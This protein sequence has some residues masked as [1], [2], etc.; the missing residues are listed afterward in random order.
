M[1]GRGVATRRSYDEAGRLVREWAEGNEAETAVSYHYDRWDECPVATCSRGEGKLVGVRYPLQ[2][3]M[4]AFGIDRL[5]YDE[6]G[7]QVRLSRELGSGSFD[8]AHT[9]DNAGRPI[10]T[11]YPTGRVLGRVL[12]GLGRVLA[13][14]GYVEEVRHTYDGQLG[15]YLLANGV[16]SRMRYDGRLRLSELWTRHRPTVRAVQ[17]YKYI[18]DRVGNLLAI[19][20]GDTGWQEQ[21]SAARYQ[22]DAWYRLTRARLEPG[23]DQEETVTFT[24]DLADNLTSMTSS[25][26]SSPANL[27]DYAYGPYQGRPAGPH[28]VSRAGYFYHRYDAAGQVVWRNGMQFA[29]DH[30]GRLVE[31]RDGPQWQVRYGYGPGW[32]RVVKREKA[33]TTYYLAGDFEVRDGIATTYLRIG[34]QRVVKIEEAGLGAKMVGDLAPAGAPDGKLTSADVRALAEAGATAEEVTRAQIAAAE[35]MMLRG[36]ERVTYLHGDHLGTVSVTTDELGAEVSRMLHYP[37]GEER[38]ADPLLED[39]GWTGQEQDR[40]AGV[41][42]HAARYLSLGGRW[43]SSDPLFWALGEAALERPFEAAN[44]YTYVS[45][46]PINWVDP[47]GLTDIT[48]TVQRTDENATRTLGTMAV[49]NDANGNTLNL[50][51]LE[52]PDAG[53]ANNISRINADTYDATRRTSP[54]HGEV[55]RLADQNGRTDVLIHPGNTAANTQGCILPG[56]GQTANSVTGSQNARNHLISYIDA[57]RNADNAAGMTTNISVVVNNIVPPTPGAG[58]GGAPVA[59]AAAPAPPVP[60]PIPL[61]PPVP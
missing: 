33:E 26:S 52:L 20:D 42:Y 49:T 54:K 12:D 17:D 51:T 24:H 37:Y 58:A 32:D 18:R 47:T 28:A 34:G 15:S 39:Y 23:T 27:G 7:Q 61:P 48:I 5:G 45:N 40:A 11:T 43:M 59:A 41:S 55:V 3:A 4:S 2:P 36:L 25:V 6:R 13:V 14:P 46:D 16:E 30:R 19:E 50:Y 21:T 22:Y 10:L 53:N 38:L 8:F 44:P 57:I 29:W 9:F 60:P 56:T 31:A 1:D 35:E